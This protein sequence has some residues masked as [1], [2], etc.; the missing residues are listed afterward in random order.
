M[1][2]SIGS[3]SSRWTRKS[4]DSLT[5][6]C[7][8]CRG[9][10]RETAGLRCAPCLPD[11][12]TAG[13]PRASCGGRRPP[14]T[15]SRA[16]TSTTTGGPSSTTRAPAVP[17][18][19]RRRLRLVPPLARGRRSRRR[20][21]ARRLPLLARVEPDRA[22]RGRVVRRRPRPLPAGGGGLPR[23]GHPC[24]SSRSTT[25][26]PPGG[27]PPGAVG[28]RRT[29]PTGSPG[30]PAG[31]PPHLGDVIGMACTINEPNVVGLMGY[32]LG[33]F[34]PGVRDDL[35]R[36]VVVNQSMVRAHRLAVDALRA[37]PGQLP[38]RPHPVD[39]RTGRPGTAGRR[40]SPR[41]RSCWRTCSS[42][43]PPG[44]TS[45]ASSATPGSVSVPDGQLLPAADGVPVTQMGYEYW[46]QAARAHRPAGRRGDRPAG[47]RHRERHR[48]RRRRP[49]RRVRTPTRSGV[50]TAVWT[51]ASTSVATSTWSLLD[52]FEWAYGYGP[53]FGLVAVDRQTFERRPKPS[54]TWF[55]QVARDNTL[56]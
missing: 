30:S 41:R 51:T 2:T 56:A 54:A 15:R 46:P 40:G 13:S 50:F 3:R 21:R 22:G 39:G 34:P 25:S 52:N 38:G 5:R 19:E 20:P 36:H 26:R 28:S 29:R 45:S 8:Q 6:S 14:P 11:D 23:A 49:A 1:F 55:G 9:G 53:T 27:W 18:S 44:T 24:R 16:A 17:E 4:R 32:R 12:P 47:C 48:H 7:W 35:A 42:A 33:V 10:R 37:G 43:P 31:S